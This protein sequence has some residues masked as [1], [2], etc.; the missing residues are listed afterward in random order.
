MRPRVLGVNQ[1]AG[2]VALPKLPIPYTGKSDLFSLGAPRL[3]IQVSYGCP[4]AT[5]SKDVSFSFSESNLLF[6]VTLQ[7]LDG[8]GANGTYFDHLME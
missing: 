1:L 2:G 6:M 3:N 8:G 4:A 5:S 7:F